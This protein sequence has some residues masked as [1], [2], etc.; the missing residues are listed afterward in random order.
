MAEPILPIYELNQDKVHIYIYAK[1]GVDSFCR[2]FSIVPRNN[3]TDG[4]TDGLTDGRTDGR[5]D[6]HA[7][8]NNTIGY[9]LIAESNYGISNFKSTIQQATDRFFQ[10][11]NHV[12]LE[13][14]IHVQ[15]N[16]YKSDR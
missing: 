13:C 16:V 3:V 6:G 11:V 9:Y 8:D 14:K 7:D 10:N 5:N 2:F 1:F 15:L 12:A 4:R